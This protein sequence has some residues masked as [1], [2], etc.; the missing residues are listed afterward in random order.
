MKVKSLLKNKDVSHKLIILATFF[1]LVIFFS[2]MKPSY[3]S[4]DNIMTILLATCVNGYD[5]FLRYE[6]HGV[7]CLAFS[8]LACDPVRFP[9]GYPVWRH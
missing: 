8:D 4:Y 6:R 3:A 7:Y 5:I 2:I 9:G 1:L